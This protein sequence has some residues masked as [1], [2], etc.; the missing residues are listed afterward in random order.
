VKLVNPSGKGILVNE[1]TNTASQVA[2]GFFGSLTWK[3]GSL[4]ADALYRFN[5]GSASRYLAQYAN[6]SILSEDIYNDFAHYQVGISA[7]V[8]F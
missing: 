6:T 5:T 2:G 7:G 8:G 1:S 3:S 4:S